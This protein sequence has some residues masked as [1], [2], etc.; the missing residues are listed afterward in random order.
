MVEVYITSREPSAHAGALRHLLPQKS[1]SSS[2][3]SCSAGEASRR[4]AHYAGPSGVCAPRLRRRRSGGSG[5]RSTRCRPAGEHPFLNRR[6]RRGSACARRS[7]GRGPR[8]EVANVIVF[9]ASDYSS[10]LSERPISV[11]TRPV[12]GESGRAPRAGGPRAD[13][14]GARASAVGTR[15]RPGV[16]TLVTGPAVDLRQLAPRWTGSARFRRRGRSAGERWRCGRPLRR[17][18]ARRAGALRA[19]A[20]LVRSTRGQGG[21][22]PTSCGTRGD[23][24]GHRPGFLAPIT[25]PCCGGG[26]RRTHPGRRAAEGRCRPGSRRGPR[27]RAGAAP[28]R[29]RR[30]GSAVTA[31]RAAAYA[32]DVSDLISP[33]HHGPPQ[34]AVASHAQTLR[35]FGRVVHRGLRA[36][37][38]TWW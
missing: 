11:S 34:G 19:G 31:D 26:H 25:P 13:L 6:S 17:V 20:V 15:R 32:G 22:A 27:R 4:Q 23:D 28:A 36:V 5:V 29:G 14:I 7:F 2:T 12:S 8:R 1:G 35:T 24:A 37:T 9:L 10:Y 3:S 16:R 33:R 38:G 30:G 21:E 18:D